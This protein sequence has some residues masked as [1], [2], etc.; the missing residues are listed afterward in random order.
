LESNIG[1]LPPPVPEQI[2]RKYRDKEGVVIGR[3]T[4]PDLGQLA[5]RWREKAEHTA[6][7][8]DRRPDRC[9]RTPGSSLRLLVFGVPHRSAPVPA[10]TEAGR[11]PRPA[12]L[13]S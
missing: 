8:N 3:L 6:P 13:Q 1:R 9:Q 11:L 12:L 7:E 5:Q 10:K 4:I 2:H